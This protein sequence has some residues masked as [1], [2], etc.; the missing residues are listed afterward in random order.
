[1]LLTENLLKHLKIS[2]FTFS[3]VFAV[4]V[5]SMELKTDTNKSTTER[6]ATTSSVKLDSSY[7]LSSLELDHFMG[8]YLEH[9]YPIALTND[10]KVITRE[11]AVKDADAAKLASS[12]EEAAKRMIKQ[13]AFCSYLIQQDL[14]VPTSSIC[15]EAFKD[16]T[17]TVA[18][19]NS[20]ESVTSSKFL[21][22]SA[23][24]AATSSVVEE[25][26]KEVSASE[27]VETAPVASGEN[28]ALVKVLDSESNVKCSFKTPITTSGTK[29]LVE[30]KVPKAF[31]NCVSGASTKAISATVYDF[32]SNEADGKYV[33]QQ[34]IVGAST[35][36]V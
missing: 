16:E 30:V 11:A 4:S 36:L 32:T 12:D 5:N 2:S 17:F 22:T 28:F 33:K 27:V 24:A 15:N 35:A 6:H 18:Y 23:L 29:K 21:T 1:M 31:N 10:G 8:K 26:I 3:M 19:K 25:S 20:S 13:V 7:T 14:Y 9:A 34:A